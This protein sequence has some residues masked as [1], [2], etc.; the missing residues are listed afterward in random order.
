M[1]DF[2]IFLK[3]KKKKAKKVGERYQNLTEEEK[4]KKHNKNLYEEQKQKLIESR[5]NYYL[6]DIK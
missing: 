1:K 4:E 3:N 6:T 2:K 5:R